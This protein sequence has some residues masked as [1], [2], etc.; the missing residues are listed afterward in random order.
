MKGGGKQIAVKVGNM[1]DHFCMRGFF[2]FFFWGFFFCFFLQTKLFV[3]GK[4][5]KKVQNA[6]PFKKKK[7]AAGAGVLTLFSKIIKMVT[8][9]SLFV[10]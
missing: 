7:K 9:R 2:F 10:F 8:S 6:S 5:K 3:I 1:H 4:F